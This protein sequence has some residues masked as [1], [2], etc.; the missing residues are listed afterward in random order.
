MTRTHQWATLTQTARRRYVAEGGA[1]PPRPSPPPPPPSAEDDEALD[2]EREEE[3]EE[4]PLEEP[5]PDEEVPEEEGEEDELVP[6][7]VP[8]QAPPIWPEQHT[9]YSSFI[10]AREEDE[11]RQ[12]RDFVM[13]ANNAAE[14]RRGAVAPDTR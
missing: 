11:R 1:P 8:V 2:F 7:P 4:D 10:T 9:A 12:F 5:V 13:A 6:E 3:G 14:A